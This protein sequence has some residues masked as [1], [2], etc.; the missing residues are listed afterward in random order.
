[1]VKPRKR[2]D[3]LLLKVLSRTVANHPADLDG[4]LTLRVRE[5]VTLGVL[6]L[7]QRRALKLAVEDVA[8]ANQVRQ[9]TPGL[10]RLSRALG[11]KTEISSNS[12]E[13][14]GR[15]PDAPNLLPSS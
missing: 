5:Q 10:G 15:R 4:V 9:E 7:L 14:R 6:P 1:M 8:F 12:K 13:I 3:S 11:T 2:R